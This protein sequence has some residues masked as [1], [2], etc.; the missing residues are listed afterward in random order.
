MNKLGINS[1]WVRKIKDSDDQQIFINSLLCNP[2]IDRLRD[3]LSQKLEDRSVF[4]EVDYSNPSWAYT[5]ADRNGY[6][7]A[8]REILKLL[9]TKPHDHN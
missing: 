2:V 6:T 5:S 1:E 4:K 7:R 9:E 3:I 8:I